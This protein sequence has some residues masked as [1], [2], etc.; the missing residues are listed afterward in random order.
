MLVSRRCQRPACRRCRNGGV[1]RP[2]ELPASADPQPYEHPAQ[3]A[4]H[5]DHS[6]ARHIVSSAFLMKSMAGGPFHETTMVQTTFPCRAPSSGESR[7]AAACSGSVGVNESNRSSRDRQI[8]IRS[9]AG[10]IVVP[11]R[12]R[13]ALTLLCRVGTNVETGSVP[14]LAHPGCGGVAVPWRLRLWTWRAG[15]RVVR[16][17]HR[18]CAKGCVPGSGRCALLRRHGRLARACR[19]TAGR[20]RCGQ[21][22]IRNESGKAIRLLAEDFV[23]IGKGGQK[24]RPVPVLPLDGENLPRLNPVY[25]STKFYVA[26]RFRDAYPT[27]EPW[28]ARLERDD[29]LYDRQFGR[30]AS[31]A[32]RSRW[33]GWPFLMVSWT[34]AA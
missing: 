28:S 31:G 33:S 15:A 7:R 4:H 10:T 25:A 13:W 16:E 23:L 20:C 34:T 1:P 21:V 18:G 12:K 27:L 6:S 9:E 24:Y 22:R 2:A 14:G 32:R 19:E 29:A 5:E 17:D 3:G 8:F 26:P 30:W 11:P